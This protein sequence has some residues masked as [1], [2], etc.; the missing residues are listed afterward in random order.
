MAAVSHLRSSG[1]PAQPGRFIQECSGS[2]PL[3]KGLSTAQGR[4]DLACGQRIHGRGDVRRRAVYEPTAGRAQRVLHQHAVQLDC[5][6]RAVAIGQDDERGA[7]GHR[8]G[9]WMTRL[10]PK[11]GSRPA[12]SSTPPNSSKR[13]RS[14]NTHVVEVVPNPDPTLAFLVHGELVAK[15][16]IHLHEN[17]DLSQLAEDE[18]YQFAYIFVRVPIAGGTGSP[19]SPIAVR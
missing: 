14:T 12:K 3:F 17:L 16:G 4:F 19:G 6:L 5:A 10:A 2:L 7:G 9:A 1:K 11:I 15:N 8:P 18:V 13:A